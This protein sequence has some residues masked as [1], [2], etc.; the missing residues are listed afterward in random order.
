MIDYAAA[1]G[2]MVEEQIAA[3]GIRHPAVLRAMRSVPREHFVPWPERAY[4]YDDAPLPIGEGQT[5]SQPYVVALMAEALD[6]AATDRVLEIGTGSGYSAA[7]LAEIVAEVY[8]IER[9]EGL[10]AAAEAR[11][12]ALGYRNVHVR[13]GDGTLGWPEHAPFDGVVVTAGGPEVPAPLLEQLAV[14]ARLVMPVG[15]TPRAQQLVRVTRRG[16]ADY[17]RVV[18]GEVAFVPLIGTAGWP[19]ARA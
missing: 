8:T 7:V 12:A 11:L 19:D 5:I 1:R 15:H 4:A 16:E 18:L 17:D 9:L 13:C 14:G 6:P 3:R 2:R 10:A